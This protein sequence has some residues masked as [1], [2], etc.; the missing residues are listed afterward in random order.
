MR[1]LIAVALFILASTIL[2]AQNTKVNHTGKC[3]HNEAIE[4]DQ[5]SYAINSQPDAPAT[6]APRTQQTNRKPS[7]E[8]IN[9]QKIAFF[10][11]ELN[12]TPQEAEKFWPVYNESWHARGK[13][14][15]ETMRSLDQLNQ[16]LEATPSVSDMRIQ[17]LS[18]AYIQNFKKEGDIFIAYFNDFKKVL[19]LR[20]AVKVFS[21]E[22]KFRVILIKQLR[23]K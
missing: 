10:T 15:R 14:R 19:P 11:Q 7:R 3:Q 2:T 20:K 21:A 1:F 5:K 23:G 22:E 13:A 12:L 9:A 8:E 6:D 17:E 4:P 18:D 16:A